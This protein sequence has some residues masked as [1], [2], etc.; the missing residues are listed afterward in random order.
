MTILSLS[1]WHVQKPESL[2]FFL[3]NF[4]ESA[5]TTSQQW[6]SRQPTTPPLSL[7]FFLY[8]ILV[9]SLSHIHIETRISSFFPHKFRRPPHYSGMPS[10]R[11]TTIDAFL[12]PLSNSR[13]LYLSLTRTQIWNPPPDTTHQTITTTQMP[14]S[15]F[16][17]PS[18]IWT[19]NNNR[20]TIVVVQ[21]WLWL[22]FPSLGRT[23]TIGMIWD[24]YIGCTIWESTSF[25][26]T[27]YIIFFNYVENTKIWWDIKQYLPLKL[28]VK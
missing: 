5:T 27:C 16:F 17:T 4:G 13:S 26:T 7:S 2:L 18:L 25:M 9:L 6:N 14:F 24:F 10:S 12:L 11:H 23:T 28:F 1:L 20:V 22:T 3:T 21:P 8:L 19:N 15:W